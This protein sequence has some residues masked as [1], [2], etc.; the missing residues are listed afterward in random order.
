[1]ICENAGRMAEHN[2]TTIIEP[3]K[4]NLAGLKRAIEKLI[5]NGAEGIIL[6]CTEIPLLVDQKHCRMPVFDTTLI[7]ARAAVREALA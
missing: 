3:V 5:E 4:A 1:M 2:V 7:H 6:G